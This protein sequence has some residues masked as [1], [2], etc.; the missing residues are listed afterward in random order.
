MQLQYGKSRIYLFP[1]LTGI[2]SLR[3]D[4][5]LRLRRGGADKTKKDAESKLSRLFSLISG[6]SGIRTRGTVT[7]TSV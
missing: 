3:S 4:L 6:E 7:R 1:A 2:S 5:P